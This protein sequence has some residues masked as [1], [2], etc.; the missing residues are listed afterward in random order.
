MA[1]SPPSNCSNWQA[2]HHR[3]IGKP[4]VLEVSGECEFPSSGYKVALRRAMPQGI[5]PAILV[6]E[7]VVTPPAGPSSDVMSK[8][9]VKYSEQTSSKYTSVQI[10]PEGNQIEVREVF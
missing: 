5:N 1:N 10:L 8:I 9:S 4:Q 3:V 6:L 2:V 7:K